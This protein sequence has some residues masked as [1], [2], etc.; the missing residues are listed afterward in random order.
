MRATIA[1]SKKS[2]AMIIVAMKMTLSKPRLVWFEDPKLS[3]PPKAPPA[4]DS[5][6]CSKI[7]TTKRTDRVIWI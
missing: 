4:L 2:T 6:F 7:A 5:E 3:P 1:E